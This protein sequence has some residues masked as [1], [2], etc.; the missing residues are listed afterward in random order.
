MQMREILEPMMGQLQKH[1]KF[2]DDVMSP[3]QPQ[4]PLQASSVGSASPDGQS[5]WDRR[6]AAFKATYALMAPWN[7]GRFVI[8]D[9]IGQPFLERAFEVKGA[10]CHW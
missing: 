4:V 8:H 5:D 1:A 7:S 10:V 6:L 2:I 9:K 3:P